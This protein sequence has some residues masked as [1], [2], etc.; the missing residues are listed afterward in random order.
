MC[1]TWDEEASCK[2]T[3]TTV[4]PERCRNFPSGGCQITKTILFPLPLMGLLKSSMCEGEL[5]SYPEKSQ[6]KFSHEGMWYRFLPVV[7]EQLQNIATPSPEGSWCGTFLPF[8]VLPPPCCLESTKAD[9]AVPGG[10]C[11]PRASPGTLKS[12]PHCLDTSLIRVPLLRAWK[13]ASSEL[14]TCP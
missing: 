3:L 8:Q 5:P 14:W 1:C 4:W 13:W 6:S 7:G 12:S 10:F 2:A 11:Y 9:T